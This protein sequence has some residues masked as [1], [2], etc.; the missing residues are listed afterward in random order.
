MFGDT[1]FKTI[2]K[3]AFHRVCPHELLRSAAPALSRSDA[4]RSE[5]SVYF[6]V[7]ISPNSVIRASHSGLLFS[8]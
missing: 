2:E 8:A 4:D 7:T 1:P 6:P 5:T 3:R